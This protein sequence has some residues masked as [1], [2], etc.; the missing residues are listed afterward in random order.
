MAL[1]DLRA[2]LGRRRATTGA[3]AFPAR[4]SRARRAAEA[5]G[6]A[7]SARR[8]ATPA[9]LGIRLATIFRV[10]AGRASR[11]RVLADG[12]DS[13][14]H[15][16]G[17]DAAAAK[18]DVRDSGRPNGGAARGGRPRIKRMLVS[19][20]MTVGADARRWCDAGGDLVAGERFLRPGRRPCPPAAVGAVEQAGVQ[21]LRIDTAAAAPSVSRDAYTVSSLAEKLRIKYGARGSFLR[22]TIRTGRSSGRSP[23]PVPISS[24]FGPT[25]SAPCFGCTS[26]HEGTDFTPGAGAVIQAI[27][28]GVVSADKRYRGVRQP[29]HRSTT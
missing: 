2:G 13:H 15:A 9:S 26:Y 23:C 28:D 5:A 29:R 19:K 18:H 11:K 24:G 27:A 17:R 21:S 14:S 6:H 16:R 4:A 8:L 20:L 1:I 12:G 7:H 3:G 22:P 25:G 10:P